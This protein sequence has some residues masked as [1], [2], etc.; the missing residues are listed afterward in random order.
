M[1][2]LLF[3]CF[4]FVFVFNLF[5]CDKPKC[6][7]TNPIFENHQ[8]NSEI[9]KTELINQINSIDQSKLRYWLQK[10]DDK[11]EEESLYFYIQGAGL[12]AILHLNINNWNKLENV[13]KR[14]GVGRRGAEFTNLKFDIIKDSLTTKFVYQTFDYI[15]D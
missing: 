10:Y 12:C 11:N 3:N 8:P 2:K 1:K 13:K 7:N 9:Y 4:L 14:K 15:I 5:S 6:D